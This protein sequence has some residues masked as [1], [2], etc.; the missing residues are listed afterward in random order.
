MTRHSWIHPNPGEKPRFKTE[1]PCRKC[2]LVK[3]TDHQDPH[4]P[5]PIIRWF[6]PDI[7]DFDSERTPECPPKELEKAA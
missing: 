5:F 7:G 4:R 3:I 6:H 2:G 1:R